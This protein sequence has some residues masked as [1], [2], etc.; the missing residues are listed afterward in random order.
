[1]TT[2][3]NLYPS[4]RCN[5]EYI[6]MMAKEAAQN[7]YKEIRPEKSGYVLVNKRL[8]PYTFLERLR[9]QLDG[10]N[11]DYGFVLS[12]SAIYDDKF[13]HSLCPDEREVLMPC[14]LILI[15]RGEFYLNLFELTDEEKAA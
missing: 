12:E 10:A 9:S 11:F 14:T 6:E 4:T 13:L 8:V 5:A 3:T 2:I 1:M 7:D 15:E